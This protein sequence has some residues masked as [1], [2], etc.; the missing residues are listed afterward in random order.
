MKY[1][2]TSIMDRRGKDAIAVDCLG[3]GNASFFPGKPRE[4]YDAIPMWVADMNFPACPTIP[5][6][7]IERAKHPAYGYFNL[8]DEYFDRIIE[9]QRDRNG[10]QGL[11]R[12]EIG[13][14]NGVLGG[15]L[16]ALGAFCS[17]GDYVLLQD[18]AFA[19]APG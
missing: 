17:K 9:W 15:V 11:T 18:R 12:E 3:E 4:G 19:F 16:S 13:Y 10:V 1:D 6:T 14:E 7:I 5:E 2:F 8:R